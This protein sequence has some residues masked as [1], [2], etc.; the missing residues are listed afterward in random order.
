MERRWGGAGGGRDRGKP[1]L[2]ALWTEAFSLLF[3]FTHPS[4]LTKLPSSV[5][6]L[7]C[8]LSPPNLRQWTREHWCSAASAHLLIK[9]LRS[10]FPPGWEFFPRQAPCC[11]SLHLTLPSSFASERLNTS[12]LRT[13]PP[14]ACR[15]RRSSGYTIV[16]F[17]GCN[18]KNALLLAAPNSH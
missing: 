5:S 13:I 15:T 18:P 12:F 6:W 7:R 11:S 9:S 2:P 3:F 1:D 8:R 17:T 4:L 10:L 14:P 16:K